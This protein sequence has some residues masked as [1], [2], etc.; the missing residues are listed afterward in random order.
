[1]Q[2]SVRNPNVV[3]MIRCDG[4]IAVAETGPVCVAIWRGA[5]TKT[6]FEWQRAGLAETV[7]RHPR[8]AAFMCV[9]ETSAK[10][11]DDELRKASAQL[12][13]S[14][15]DRLKCTACVI[16]GEGFVTAMHRGV[17]TG[18]ILL[19]MKRKSLISVF[20]TV[21]DSVRW[22][23]EYLPL[24]SEQEIISSVEYVRSRFPSS[25]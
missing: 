9:V 11:P 8:G 22:M 15:G 5:V 4:T 18:M 13:L 20:A 24:P 12:I 6:P 1:M 19:T 3:R 2:E 14:H 7:Q 10:P 25:S 17:L 21:P 23:R 16:E